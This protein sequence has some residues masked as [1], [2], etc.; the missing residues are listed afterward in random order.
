CQT[1]HREEAFCDKC[2]GPIDMPHSDNW[3]GEHRSFLREKEAD[4]CFACHKPS[5]CEQCHSVHGVHKQYTNFDYSKP[6]KARRR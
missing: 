1:C 5:Q 6:A 4:V 2:H 3:L